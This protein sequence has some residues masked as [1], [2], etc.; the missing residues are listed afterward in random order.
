MKKRKMNWEDIKRIVEF[1]TFFV[2]VFLAITGVFFLL[3]DY[4]IFKNKEDSLFRGTFSDLGITFI[5]SSTVSLIM[6][7]FLRIDIVDFMTERML[8]V[9]PE[10]I[11]GN[12]GVSEFYKDRKRIDFKEYINNSKGFLKIIGV[13]SNDILAS[14]NMPIIKKKIIDNPEFKIQILLLSPWSYTAEIRSSAKT[15]RTHY[16]GI[17]KTQA[18]I[19]DICNL[20]ENLKTDGIEVEQKIELR[21][22]DDIP[23]LS[24][25]IDERS[26]IVAPFMVVEQG[27][28]SPYYIAKKLEIEDGIYDLYCDH[29]D[30]IWDKA[31]IVNSETSLDDI[32]MAQKAKDLERVEDNPDSYSDWIL[33][34]NN[35]GVN[36][37]NNK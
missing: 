21:L 15:Y 8:R 2:V 16:E 32:Y 11:K 20:L 9:M 24:L 37:R 29:F 23:S 19:L 10:N 35:V 1:K 6:E 4:F 14:A 5:T 34:L 30:T 26:A 31:T 12:T 17:V 7:I 22:Y 27:G 3:L 18:V 33:S 25:V 28:S 36:R 13:S